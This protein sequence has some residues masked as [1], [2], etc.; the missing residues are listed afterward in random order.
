MSRQPTKECAIW[1]RCV[2]INRGQEPWAVRRAGI[3]GTRG[4]LAPARMDG[5]VIS[6]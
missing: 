3:S 5:S 2:F 4:D 1:T 6:R